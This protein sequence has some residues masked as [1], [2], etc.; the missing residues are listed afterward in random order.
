MP[1]RTI[2]SGRTKK[3][4]TLGRTGSRIGIFSALTLLLFAA[5]SRAQDAA[6]VNPKTIHVTLD[7]E[8]VRVFEAV[9]PPGAKEQM[10]S[11]PASIVYV[12]EG[13]R[14]RNHAVNGN[15]TEAKFHAGG[16]SYR[17]PMTHWAENIGTTT[18][19]LVVVELKTAR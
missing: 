5:T 14:V 19:R 16:T 9:L 10:H 2:D 17:P 18:I 12:I 3:E 13:G 11:H 1:R 6:A 15:V 8:R 4:E 7:N